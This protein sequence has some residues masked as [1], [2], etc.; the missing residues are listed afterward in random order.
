MQCCEMRKQNNC[1][2][3]C[4]LSLSLRQRVRTSNDDCV[5]M[6]SGAIWKPSAPYMVALK[7]LKVTQGRSCCCCCC[8]SCSCI[9]PSCRSIRFDGHFRLQ[10]LLCG[11][12]QPVLS[13][14][15]V[16]RLQPCLD[17]HGDGRGYSAALA[18]ASQSHPFYVA[19]Y[20]LH[21]SKC[22]VK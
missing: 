3:F 21:P 19:I 18:L 11:L 4:Y 9:T 20:G 8:C 16:S 10:C 5:M 7:V 6:T 2:S 12:L 15:T 13:T 14:W 17:K 1:L 22:A